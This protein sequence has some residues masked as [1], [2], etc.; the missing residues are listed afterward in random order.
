MGWGRNSEG[1]L[2]DGTTTQRTTPVQIG[3]DNFWV[4]IAPGNL[5]SLAL[6]SGRE[7]FCATGTNYDAQLGDNT[8]TNKT[9][10]VCNTNSAALPVTFMSISANRITAGIQVNWKV[11]GESGISNY[12][13]ERSTDGRNFTTAGTVIAAGSS[14]IQKIYNWID[15]NADASTCFTG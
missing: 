8:T 12:E 5:H 7:Q 6:K 3:T 4:D 9:S 10:F 13:I 11:A 2:G 1:Q 15:V 14:S